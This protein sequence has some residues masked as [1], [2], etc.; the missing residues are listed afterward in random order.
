MV[1]RGCG[2]GYCFG[3]SD[4]EDEAKVFARGGVGGRGKGDCSGEGGNGEGEWGGRE[5]VG[6]E[7]GV[8]GRDTRIQLT[9][10]GSKRR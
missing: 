6:G 4:S 5:G 1:A 8:E 9:C 10:K 3:G 2:T 7:F